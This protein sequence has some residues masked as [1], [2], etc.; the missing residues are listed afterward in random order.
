MGGQGRR[1][2]RPPAV[3]AARGGRADVASPVVCAGDGETEFA[4][5]KLG[6][7]EINF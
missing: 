3:R 6:L 5:R 7:K 1:G 4:G 2:R